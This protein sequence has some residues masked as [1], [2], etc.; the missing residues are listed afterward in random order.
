MTRTD[1]R[2]LA[3]YTLERKPLGKVTLRTATAHFHIEEIK[4]IS[5]TGI[6]FALGHSE[7]V[8]SKVSI[9]YADAKIRFEVFGRIAWC[10]KRCDMDVG[11][12]GDDAYMLG[13]ELLATTMLFVMLKSN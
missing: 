1:Q 6:S 11:Q 3:R 8:S 5:E 4:D 13:V 7:E 12:S 9:E 2:G 10:A